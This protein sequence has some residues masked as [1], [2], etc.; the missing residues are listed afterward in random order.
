MIETWD[1]ANSLERIGNLAVIGSTQR[2][3]RT[4]GQSVSNTLELGLPG[5]AL[6]T[7]GSKTVEGR[8]DKEC[9]H[10]RQQH[11]RKQS[12]ADRL[13]DP[14]PHVDTD[15]EWPIAKLGNPKVVA[16]QTFRTIMSFLVSASQQLINFSK[17]CISSFRQ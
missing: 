6:D 7:G 13:S 17:K 16:F 2:L 4:R 8:H 10:N 15:F 3:R 12:V 9:W 11:D 1:L 5:Q 14:A